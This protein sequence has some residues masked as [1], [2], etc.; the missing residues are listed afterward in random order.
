MV[1]PAGEPSVAEKVAKRAGRSPPR[2]TKTFATPN[3]AF[4]R[5]PPA[6]LRFRVLVRRVR[7]S[8]ADVDAQTDKGRDDRPDDE[9]HSGTRTHRTSRPGP[10]GSNRAM[11][12]SDRPM[13]SATCRPTRI[14]SSCPAGGRA[15][16]T[17]G[18]NLAARLMEGIGDPTKAP[19]AHGPGRSRPP[20]D[21]PQTP[22]AGQR[23]GGA[24][25]RLGHDE[26]GPGRLRGQ[27]G[28]QPSRTAPRAPRS[29]RG[30]RPPASPRPR[31]RP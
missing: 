24:L 19:T 14:H 21:V 27:A 22:L 9:H 3:S 16:G 5:R 20:G 4:G 29:A 1:D 13:R 10:P 15:L 26:D 2:L 25:R 28:S 23:G 6:A 31:G 17:V 18:A 30:R 7:V 12:T 11:P 8:A